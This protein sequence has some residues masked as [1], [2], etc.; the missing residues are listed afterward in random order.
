MTKSSIKTRLGY[1]KKS[2]GRNSVQIRP[3][4]NVSLCVKSLLRWLHEAA[5][6]LNRHTRRHS[7]SSY[8]HSRPSGPRS[9][10]RHLVQT[11]ACRRR[12]D[13]AIN[14]G[15]WGGGALNQSHAPADLSTIRGRPA[16]SGACSL[17]RGEPRGHVTAGSLLVTRTKRRGRREIKARGTFSC[18]PL[19][20]FITC[21]NYR[22][23]LE[24][25]DSRLRRRELK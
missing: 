4:R 10:V 25:T 11:A 16:I 1:E 2:W 23:Y 22:H 9:P 5:R 15:G 8:R 12:R 14:Q 24:I 7:R 13:T 20:C 3:N 17:A 21:K 6:H 19:S 18:R